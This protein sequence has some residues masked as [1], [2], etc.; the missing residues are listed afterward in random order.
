[1]AVVQNGIIENYH[2]L[3]EELQAEGVVFRVLASGSAN[4]QKESGLCL[5]QP[6]EE[7]A[8]TKSWPAC[9]SP[10]YRAAQPVSNT[11]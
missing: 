9:C 11:V 10:D 4:A 2:T 3:R 6:P 1:V 8:G 5:S 7:P